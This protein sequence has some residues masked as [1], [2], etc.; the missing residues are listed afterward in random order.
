[1][2]KIPYKNISKNAKTVLNLHPKLAVANPI[3]MVEVKT[4]IQKCFY[5]QRLNMKSEEE[6]NL[7]GET[8]E[9]AEKREREEQRSKKQ[10]AST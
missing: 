9:E 10:V 7:A 4:E 8:E 2:R 6:R 1:M 5:K 3:K